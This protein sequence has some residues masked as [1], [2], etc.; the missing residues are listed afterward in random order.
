MLSVF[1]FL[2]TVVYLPSPIWSMSTSPKILLL[3]IQLHTYVNG[4]A[5]TQE[6]NIQKHTENG[7]L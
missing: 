4:A 3:V 2:L 1:S 5:A 7:K 6:H